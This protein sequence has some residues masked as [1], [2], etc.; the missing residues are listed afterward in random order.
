MPGEPN[1]GHGGQRRSPAGRAVWCADRRVAGPHSPRTSRSA[2]AVTA[3]PWEVAGTAN[4][5]NGAPEA[6]AD[7][8]KQH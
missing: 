4:E 1:A 7:L 3:R 2:A 6:G 8:Q 5:A